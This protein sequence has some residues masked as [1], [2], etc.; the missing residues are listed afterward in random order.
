M[1][2]ECPACGNA[3]DSDDEQHRF[4]LVR[5]ALREVYCSASC[6]RDRVRAQRMASARLRRTLL[7]SGAATALVIGV[8][9]G[10]WLRFHAPPPAAISAAWPD[11]PI[12][13]DAPPAP[14][15]IFFG[16][17]WPPS[18]EDWMY[19]FNRARWMYPLPGPTRRPPT[20]SA[21]ILG[22][23]PPRAHPSE[24]RTPNRCG[25]ELG[26]ELWGEHVYA[27]HDGVVD[28]VRSDGNDDRGGLYVRLSHFGG[29]VFSQYFHLAATP[30]KLS[31]GD[32]VKA[33]EVIGLLGDTGTGGARR[34][35]HFA[36]SV[37]PSQDM[38][39][40]YWDPTVLMGT[41]PLRT[42]SNGTVAGLAR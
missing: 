38:S 16:P 6:L 25:V 19:A 31:R 11:G 41:W 27:V 42:P 18:D 22:P 2:K 14:K 26:G 8:V 28:R 10:G 12:R 37:R 34:H 30:R 4:V 9:G 7:L 35:L 20:A 17:A 39:E 3:L 15:M 1:A 13:V 33:G 36:L 40:I 24:C 5:R 29:M 23:E 21:G 32:H